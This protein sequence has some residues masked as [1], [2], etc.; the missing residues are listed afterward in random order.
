MKRANGMGT[1][2]CAGKNRRKP[3]YA[4]I[5]IGWNNDGKAIYKILSDKYG[6]KYFRK[7]SE[8]DEV[9]D[10]YNKYKKYINI[11]KQDYTFKQ[12]YEEYSNKYFPTPEEV[13]IEKETHEKAKG[14]FGMSNANNLKSAY[15]KCGDLYNKPYKSLKKHDFEEIILR[16]NGCATV[17]QSL[18][19]LFRKLDNYAL[20][21]DIILKGYADLI[22]ITE[23]MY[24]PTQ[25]EGI[26]Y[27]YQEIDRLWKH[28]ACL[29]RDIILITIYTG[30]RIEEVLFTKIKDIH[31]TDGYFIAGLKTKSGKRRI[32]PIHKDILY[33]IIKYFNL[34]KEN[35]FLFTIDNKKIDYNSQFLD[36]YDSLMLELNMPEHET[37]DGRKTISTEFDRVGANKICVNKILGHK[38][39]NIG[40]DVYTKKSLEELKHTINLV[41]YKAKKGIEYTYLSVNKI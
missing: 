27:T 2:C 11:E 28:K 10:D 41:D 19:N 1:V 4:R 5:T 37:H 13:K 16:T 21:Y 35:T 6:E 38:S 32:I 8:A 29:E 33:I 31:I 39:G 9:L 14:K 12:V 15:K 23:D 20:E 40:D 17:I 22:K 36:M 24:N 3:Y 26:P 18:A 34:N 25:R 30:L 7:Y